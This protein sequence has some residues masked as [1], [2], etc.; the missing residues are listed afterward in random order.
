MIKNYQSISLTCKKFQCVAYEL[1]PFNFFLSDICYKIKNETYVQKLIIENKLNNG[2]GSNNYNKILKW[3]SRCGCTETIRLLLSSY[4]KEVNPSEKSSY[5]IRKAS[6]YGHVKIVELL[7]KDNR[8]DPS[9]YNNDAIV[10]A[11]KRGYVEIVDL[12]LK[13]KRVNPCLSTKSALILACLNGHF[14]VVKLI[15]KHKKVN[16]FVLNDF[17]V[18]LTSGIGFR[19]RYILLYDNGLM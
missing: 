19:E 18:R 7:L 6:K 5:T 3:A 4:S 16:A 1:F 15:L 14:E 12:L 13:D 2:N 11:S 9:A 8:A 17:A 10:D